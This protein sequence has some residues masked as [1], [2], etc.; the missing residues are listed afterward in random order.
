MMSTSCENCG[1]PARPGYVRCVYCNRPVSAEAART[2]IPC[3][4]CKELNLWGAQQCVSCAAWIVVQCV[5]CGGLSPYTMS[6][7]LACNEAFAGSAERKAAREAQVRQQQ[8]VQT[9]RVVGGVAAS[10]LGAMT[11]GIIGGMLDDD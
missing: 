3:P 11:G 1:G 8:N 5:F 4:N 6:A 9:A 7:C 10:F 2:A